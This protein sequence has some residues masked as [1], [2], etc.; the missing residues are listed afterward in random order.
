MRCST[1]LLPE[2]LC[3][4]VVRLRSMNSRFEFAMGAVADQASSNS[5]QPTKSPPSAKKRSRPSQLASFGSTTRSTS[6]E[7]LTQRWPV[8]KSMVTGRPNAAR[9]SDHQAWPD[10]LISQLEQWASGDGPIEQWMSKEDNEE[11]QTGRNGQER[12]G[13]GPRRR[14]IVPACGGLDQ[15]DSLSDDH[16]SVGCTCDT[17]GWH[18][19]LRHINLVVAVRA[20]VIVLSHTALLQ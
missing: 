20:F 18:S 17:S 4:C 9:H 3:L 2:L 1:D 13:R 12:Q 14:R 10:N 5:K 16:S 7:K 8:F 6:E 11:T 19:Q 15:F